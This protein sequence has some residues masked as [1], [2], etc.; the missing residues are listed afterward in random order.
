MLNSDPTE[1]FQLDMDLERLNR[2]ERLT[3]GSIPFESW[4]EKAGRYLKLYP[5][6]NRL[7]QQSLS[8]IRAPANSYTIQ[9]P[10]PPPAAVINIVV[11]EKTIHRND[12]VSYAFLEGGVQAGNG[13][14]CLK[15]SRYDNGTR[16][17][18]NGSPAIYRGTGWLLSKDLIMTNHHVINARENNES[19]AAAEDFDL[20]A[21]HAQAW[22]DYNADNMEGI[23]INIKKPEACDYDL[24]F[25]ILRLEKPAARTPLRILPSKIVVMPG[26]A[27][28]VN[29][30]Q[31]PLG[32]AK[33][34]ALRNNNV[35]ES[36]YPCVRYFTDT[37][38]GSSGAPVF[39]DNW[40]VIALHRAAVVVDNVQY[41]GQLT[42]WVNEGIQ[43]QAILEHL[44][45]HHPALAREINHG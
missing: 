15:V 17:M 11:K 29:I 5:A 40:E 12:M 19:R 41:N 42:A 27:P 9:D 28:V 30:I 45:Q 26:E 14:A 4:L 18:L 2:T 39:N 37:E 31:H 35:F 38:G 3:D 20:Q 33:K 7:V 6:A 43:I 16:K 13:V 25:A 8:A 24:D 1:K 22:F 44:R 10:Q 34:V 36:S 21:A 23:L 32:Y